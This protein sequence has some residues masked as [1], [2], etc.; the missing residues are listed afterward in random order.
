MWDSL[1]II[2]ECTGEDGTSLR[3]ACFP[4]GYLNQGTIARL[5]GG[6][7]RNAH[8]R[9]RLRGDLRRKPEDLFPA[10]LA[11]VEARVLARMHDLCDRIRQSAPSQKATAKRK[12]LEEAIARVAA[13]QNRRYEGPNTRVGL[14][15]NARGFAYV[16]FEGPLSPVDWGISEILHREGR[17]KTCMKR[18]AALFDRYCPDVLVLRAA[19]TTGAASLTAIIDAAEAFA[20]AEG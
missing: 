3:G 9:L 10:A 2:Y 15:P 8:R 18:L 12:L 6:M 13:R 7:S 16:I 1:A 20:R 17:L 11:S 19:G 4:I 5:E 14:Y